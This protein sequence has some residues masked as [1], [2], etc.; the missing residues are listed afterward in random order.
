MWGS[1]L[2]VGSAFMEEGLKGVDGRS[3]ID[4][5]ELCVANSLDF[6][7]GIAEMRGYDLFHQF[8]EVGEEGYGAVGFGEG[9]FTARFGYHHTDGMFPCRGVVP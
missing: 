7:G 3:A 8:A 5:S 1:A 2:D 4:A 6:D 9:W